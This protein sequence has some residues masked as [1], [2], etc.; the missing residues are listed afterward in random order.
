MNCLRPVMTQPS[1]SRVAVARSDAA[2]LPLEASVRAKAPRPEPSVS[3]GSQRARCAAVPKRTIEPATIPLLTDTPTARDG[4]AY[5]HS[6]HS[7][8]RELPDHV[9]REAPGL[10]GLRDARAKTGGPVANGRRELAL[11]GPRLRLHQLPFF[12]LRTASV[13][14]GRNSKRSPTTP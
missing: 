2:S 8:R 10:L 14:A 6:E 3:R 5:R 7:E 9:V 11:G 12:A 13:K 4:H 1:P